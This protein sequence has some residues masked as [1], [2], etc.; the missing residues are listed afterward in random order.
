MGEVEEELED[1]WRQV[2][3]LC[4]CGYV[5]YSDVCKR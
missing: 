5:S 4:V 2:G 1:D 3:A